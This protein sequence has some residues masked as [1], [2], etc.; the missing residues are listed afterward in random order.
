[1]PVNIV[2]GNG[3]NSIV[4]GNTSKAKAT[5]TRAIAEATGTASGNNSHAEG[6]S[7][8]AKATAA[9]SEGYFSK[10]VGSY[11]HAE[12][13]Y[14]ATFGSIHVTGAAN[15]TTYTYAETFAYLEDD[16][17]Y[18]IIYN[19]TIYTGSSVDV[20]N[21]TITLTT[22]LNKSAAVSNLAVDLATTP[23]AYGNRSHAEGSAYAQG[24]LSHA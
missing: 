18:L 7:T 9:H 12:G 13:G 5:G 1:M 3:T 2:D 22:T 24:Q 16:P 8:E 17:N 6:W 20:T 15:A 21:Q 11:S 10:A 14:Y 23:Y 19:N 4:L